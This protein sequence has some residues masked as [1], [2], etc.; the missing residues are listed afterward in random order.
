MH[1]IVGDA[2]VQPNGC[3]TWTIWADVNVWSCEGYVPGPPIDMCSGL[4]EAYGIYAAL[5]FLL[6]DCT[7]YPIKLPTE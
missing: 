7:C 5:S 4:A 6:E 2:T 3:S 1:F